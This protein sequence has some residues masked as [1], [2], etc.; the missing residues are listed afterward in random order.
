MVGNS[1]SAIVEAPLFGVPAVNIGGRQEGRERGG[2]V[3]DAPHEKDNIIKA[4]KKAL[5]NEDF[6][7]TVKKSANPFAVGKNGGKKI[8][9]VLASVEIDDKLLQKRLTF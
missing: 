9:R 1:S 2:N 8:A 7:R 3:I 5:F 4:I 6:R